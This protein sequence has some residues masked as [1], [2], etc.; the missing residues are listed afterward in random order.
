[1]KNSLLTASFLFF[2][3]SS[4]GQIGSL[5]LS[6]GLPQNDFK[7]NTDAVGFGGDLSLAFPFQK[8]VPIYLGVDVN[9][10]VYGLNSTDETLSAQITTSNG[11]PLGSPINIPLR[12]INTNSLFATHLFIRAQAPFEGIQPYAEVLGG[13]RYISTNV[14]IRDLTSDNRWSGDPEDDIIV[15]ETVLNDW[16]LS[17][18][19]GGGFFIKMGPGVYLDLRANF[20]RGQRAQYFDGSDTESWNVEFS[21]NPDDFTEDVRGDQLQFGTEARESTTD[22]LVI[23]VG[24]GFKI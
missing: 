16:I 13:F 7:E 12:I 3:F 4:S 11:Q 15:R 21:G 24:V 19:F 10:M 9:Y 18:G 8:G 17:Y 1:M 14:K 22:L 23:K 6:L 20:F 5:S 2:V